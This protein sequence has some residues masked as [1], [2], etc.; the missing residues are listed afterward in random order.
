ME[1]TNDGSDLGK[2][3]KQRRVIIPLTLRKLADMS[4]ISSSH[5]GRIEKGER[6]PSASVLHK[7]AEPLGLE[8]SELFTLA[9][10]LSPRLAG[11]EEEKAIYISRQLDPYVSSI[12][13][14]E[15][16]EVQRAV[17]GILVMLKNI[18]KASNVNKDD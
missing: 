15:P 4:G 5:L 11:I 8:E 1:N 6:F 9:G 2:I 10:F 13:G 16:P 12:L 3:L 14:Q 7:I 18:A 17:I